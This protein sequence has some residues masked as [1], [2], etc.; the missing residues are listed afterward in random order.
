ML[1]GQERLEKVSGLGGWILWTSVSYRIESSRVGNASIIDEDINA[2]S[3]EDRSLL[4]GR[5]D[6]G[7]GRNV[8]GDGSHNLFLH[9]A[10]Q[11]DVVS[12]SITHDEGDIIDGTQKKGGKRSTGGG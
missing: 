12:A 10:T 8:G 2:S 3:Q 5:L 4:N 7:R 9:F 11:Y 6:G 1:E